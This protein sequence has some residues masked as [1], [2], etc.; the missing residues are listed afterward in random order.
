MNLWPEVSPRRYLLCPRGMFCEFLPEDCLEAKLPKPLLIG[1]V[2]EG[3]S[4]EL[5]VTN[6]SGLYRSVGWLLQLTS[7]SVKDEVYE[8][9][10]LFFINVIYSMCKSIANPGQTDIHIICET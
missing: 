6:A 3:R 7:T 1:E 2:E 10:N 5:V 4:Y 8:S 9:I